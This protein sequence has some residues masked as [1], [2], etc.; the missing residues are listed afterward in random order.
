MTHKQASSNQTS[1][2]LQLYQKG[3][4]SGYFIVCSSKIDQL[5][6]TSKSLLVISTNGRNPFDLCQTTNWSI[7]ETPKQCLLCPM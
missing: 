6:S 2:A 3:S 7:P 1:I 4:T 5:V